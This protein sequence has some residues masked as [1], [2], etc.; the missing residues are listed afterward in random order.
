[1]HV[2]RLMMKVGYGATKYS[3]SLLGVHLTA[4]LTAK[5]RADYLYSMSL[6]HIVIRLLKLQKWM[7]T[8]YV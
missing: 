2:S 7:S 6:V 3:K 5:C 4:G 8:A 1:M